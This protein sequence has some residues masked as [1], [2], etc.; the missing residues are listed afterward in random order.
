MQ[1]VVG[2]AMPA[3][4]SIGLAVSAIGSFGALPAGAAAFLK[5][6][7]GSAAV[8]F[9]PVFG[10]FGMA[11]AGLGINYLAHTHSTRYQALAGKV[12]GSDGVRHKEAVEHLLHQL[13]ERL[14]GPND[15]LQLQEVLK[16]CNHTLVL[17]Y[18]AD[19]AG[20]TLPEED[21]GAW[22]GAN[23]A[24]SAKW[25][26]NNCGGEFGPLA[27]LVQKSLGSVEPVDS[28][29]V[30]PDNPDN[31]WIRVNGATTMSAATKLLRFAD[32]IRQGSEPPVPDV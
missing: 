17:R 5:G 2:R 19:V 10:S 9:V 22:P 1:H 21:H 18:L 8:F 15:K 16:S 31:Q 30:N 3:V 26:M 6:G 14:S 20:N 24:N 25:L 11:G 12:K 27:E 13:T 23:L 32:H 4:E 29:T 7:E 28:R